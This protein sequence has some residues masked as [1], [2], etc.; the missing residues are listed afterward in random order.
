MFLFGF[1]AVRPLFRLLIAAASARSS[2]PSFLRRYGFLTALPWLW[3]VSVPEG[4]MLSRV[5]SR[6][7]SRARCRMP[8]PDRVLGAGQRQ[9]GGEEPTTN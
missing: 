1:C 7:L 6:V 9:P 3:P 8:C 5:E 2:L 4:A